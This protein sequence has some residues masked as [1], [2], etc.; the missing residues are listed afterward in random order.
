MLPLLVVDIIYLVVWIIG[1]SVISIVAI[2]SLGMVGLVIL[3]IYTFFI[4]KYQPCFMF[5][6][7]L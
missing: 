7:K 6:Y 5:V 3:A 2:A 1:G 4:G